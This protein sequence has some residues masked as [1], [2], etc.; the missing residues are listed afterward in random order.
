V[1]YWDLR[2]TKVQEVC[3]VPIAED[4]A[5]FTVL[6][7]DSRFRIDS[8]ELRNGNVDLAQANKNTIEQRQ[9]ADAALRKAAEQRRANKGPKIVFRYQQ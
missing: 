2:E 9:R 1:R 5:S 7:S 8:I 6:P 3:G 4:G